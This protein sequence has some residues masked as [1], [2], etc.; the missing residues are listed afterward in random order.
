M[1]EIEE[2]FQELM[3]SL[4]NRSSAKEQA[5]EELFFEDAL[6]ELIVDGHSF[7]SSAEDGEGTDG[8]KYTPFK[9]RGLRIDG[10]EYIQDREIINL[11]VCDF[12]NESSLQTITQTQVNQLLSNAKNFFEKSLNDSF[13]SQLEEESEANALEVARF[14]YDF[15]EKIQ[16]VNFV[17]ITNSILSKSIK[18]LL[19]DSEDQFAK[20]PTY[21]EVWDIRRFYDNERTKAVSESILIEFEEPLPTMSA[22]LDTAKYH[23]YLCV[24]PGR[25]LAE[26]YLKYGARLLEANVRAF[27][28]FRS[29]VNK[30]IRNTLKNNPDMFFA[31]NNGITITASGCEQDIDGNITSLT[32]L[33]IVNG[34]QTTAALFHAMKNQ[35]NLEG[36]FVQTKLSILDD[37]DDENVVPNISKFSNAQN[38]I[39]DSD[40]FSNHPFHK[41]M[42]AKSRRISA[43]IRSGEVRS[44]KWFYERSRGQYQTEIGKLSASNRKLFQQEHPKSQLITKTDLGKTAVIFFGQPNRAVQGIN[45]AFMYFAKNIQKDWEVNENLFNDMFYKK[46]I[47]QQIMF[48]NCRLLA[49]ESVKG[50]II[51][52]TTA[53]SLFMLNE[54]SNS[55]KYSLPF[56]DVWGKQ[57]ISISMEKQ[58][59]KIIEFIIS[60]FDSQTQGVEGR[61]ILSFSKSKGCLEM[62]KG[63]INDLDKEAFILEDYKRTLRPI[64]DEIDSKKKAVKDEIIA[65][66]ME[67]TIKFLKVNWEEAID[68]AKNSNEFYEKDISLLSVFPKFIRGGRE[69]SP[70]Q[71]TAINSILIKMK[72]EG[73]DI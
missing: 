35:V 17:L 24:M 58:L 44:T 15:E 40:F 37:L 49:M 59:L 72:D 68:F 1:E 50:N 66:E 13:I 16:Q 62:L 38:T 52:P 34:G 8:Y 63:V 21:I 27:L 32:N 12:S 42:E 7:E 19:I 28:Q 41:N 10:Y 70:K 48:A 69:A 23:S 65:N 56:L 30:G 71:L 29:N 3:F 2:Y 43:P 22:T 46:L 60:F 14:I 31:Y 11:Y 51:Q 26:L 64:D 6:K 33:Q 39:K 5:L 54:I 61:T 25:V 18:S 73:L 4:S 55:S 20:L 47:A 9:S 53:Y 36:V 67:L 57:R 45:I